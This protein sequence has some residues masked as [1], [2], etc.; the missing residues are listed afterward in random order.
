M[1]SASS[2]TKP[3]EAVVVGGGQAGRL[4]DGAVDVGDDPAG[5]ADDVVVVV[6]D[7]RLVARHR[8]GRLDAAHQ[9]GGGER[10]EDV[11]DRL[12]G[13]IGTRWRAAP[14]IV[15]VSACGCVSTA[16]STAIRGRVTRSAADFSA[17][18]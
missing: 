13:D 9:T 14:K 2:S 7:A 8:A 6:A 15:S 3:S 16:S 10:V 17:C 18:A 5:S 1:T 12:A 11:V 4:A